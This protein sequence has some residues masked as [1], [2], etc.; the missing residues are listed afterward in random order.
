VLLHIYGDSQAAGKGDAT[1]SC[2]LRPD[3]SSKGY[4]Y[5]R[6]DRAFVPICDPLANPEHNG[7]LIPSLVDEFY[8]RTGV[9]PLVVIFTTKGSSLTP[10]AA[11][12]QQPDMYWY[13]GD[14][15]VAQGEA[16]R[17]ARI[18]F[19]QARRAATDQFPDTNILNLGA[20]HSFGGADVK[21]AMVDS[22]VTA[23]ET[24]APR[25]SHYDDLLGVAYPGFQAL[26]L[27]LTDSPGNQNFNA[28]VVPFR[29]EFNAI[30]PEERVIP[31][32]DSVTVWHDASGLPMGREHWL[33][34][35]QGHLGSLGLDYLGATLADYFY[36]P[37]EGSAGRPIAAR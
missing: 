31:Y 19:K 32:M 24:F 3:A 6:A 10:E 15:D 14:R 23:V 36:I 34:D 20:V 30:V 17:L 1:T 25:M 8:D 12:N 37:S 21:K 2:D 18:V 33:A 28:A 7:S 11:P 22:T 26:Y 35:Q 9:T 29:A 13:L 27:E 4:V 16:F 5:R